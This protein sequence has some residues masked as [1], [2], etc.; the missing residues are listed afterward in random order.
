[1]ADL[2]QQFKQDSLPIDDDLLEF[3]LDDGTHENYQSFPFVRQLDLVQ[4]GKRRIA[5][6]IRDYYRAF[7]QRSRW[8]RDDLIGSLDLDVYEKRLVEEWELV[9]EAMRDELGDA[10]AD[11]AKHE[12]ARSV[13]AWAERTIFPIRPNVTEPFV[14]RGSFHMLA[15]E[16]RIGW[17][18]EFRDHLAFLLNKEDAA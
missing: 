9:F 13:L 10:A 6:A 12:A 15:D 1:M 8:L 2:R 4:T 17:H 18:P 3:V 5:A 7:E 16:V 14:T 11:E